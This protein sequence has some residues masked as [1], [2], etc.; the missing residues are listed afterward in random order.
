MPLSR[1]SPFRNRA[2]VGLLAL[3]FAVI[4]ITSVVSVGS[5]NALRDAVAVITHTI[6]IKDTLAG[7]KQDLARLESEGLRYMVGGLKMHRD[8]LESHLDAVGDG[9]ARLG[10]LT[11]ENPRQQAQTKHL[12]AD[13]TLLRERVRRSIEIKERDLR[14]GQDDATLRRMRDGR[15]EDIVVRMRGRLAQMAEEEDRLLRERQTERDALIKQT[16][17]TLL[18]ANG[19]ALVAGLLGFVALRRAQREEEHALL[20]ELRATQ[21]HRASDEKSAFLASMSHEIRTPMNAIFGFAQLL[22]DHVDEPLQKEWVASI[23]RSGQMLLVLINDV[24]DLSKIEAGKLQLNPQ[25]TDIAELIAESVALFEPMAEAKALRLHCSI[26]PEGLEPV[27]VDAQRLRQILMN[28]LSNA[29]KHTEKGEIAVEVSMRPAP[30]GPGRDLRIQVRDTGTGI[31]PDE[32]D[33]IFEPFYQAESPDGHLRQGTGLGL[34]ITRRLVH[35]M[36]GRIHVVSRPGEGANFRVDLPDL[37]PAAP[38]AATMV[39]TTES[40]A[41]FDRLPPLRILVVDDVEWNIEVVKGYLHGS[42]HVLAIARNGE[43]ALAVARDFAPDVV[44]MDLRMPRMNGY[45]AFEAMRADPALRSIRVVAVTASNLTGDRTGPALRF[46][47]D[48]RKPYTPWE[49]LDVLRTLFGEREDVE[50]CAAVTGSHAGPSGA[51]L[52]GAPRE[53]V[54]AEWRAVRAAPLQALRTRMRVRE[55]GEFSK[56]LDILADAI[57]DPALQAEARALRIAVQRFDVSRM[58]I[59]LDRLALGGEDER[60]ETKDVH[61]AH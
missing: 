27:A 8:G 61:D 31:H 13:M 36:H 59:A 38:V 18:I 10:V 37:E 44:L 26:D 14:R 30:M 46:D 22:A 7:M 33:R 12:S 56:R 39:G 40:R 35:L 60:A 21:A 16:N 29:V 48:L 3:A 49:L 19:L 2:N 17:A 42:R 45:R 54:L 32:H 55:I 50:A 25:G 6:E 1:T 43:E 20:V 11:G 5:I 52:A 53:E 9:I 15:D 24:L 23:R 28:L 47:G 58:K 34:S 41:D 57:G 51:D 4:A